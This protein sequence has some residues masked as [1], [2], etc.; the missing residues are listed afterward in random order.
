MKKNVIQESISNLFSNSGLSMIAPS[1]MK[2]KQTLTIISAVVLIAGAPIASKAM[3]DR[4]KEAPTN[5]D[6]ERVNVRNVDTVGE[7]EESKKPT[8]S[9]QSSITT[10]KGSRPMQTDIKIDS[11]STSTNSANSSVDVNVNGQKVPVPKNGSV[12]KHLSSNNG[13]SSVNVTVDN[14]SSTHN[15]SSSSTVIIEHHSSSTGSEDNSEL[16][17][18]ARHPARR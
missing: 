1:V 17:G 16:G 12:T 14:N 7:K 13:N 18:N 2:R 15:S 6:I 3:G 8:I 10:E 9:K 4:Q 11:N 5:N